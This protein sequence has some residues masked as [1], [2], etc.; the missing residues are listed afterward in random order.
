M[1][2]KERRGR[3]DR[4]VDREDGVGARGYFVHR[5]S[6][7]RPGCA[8][9]V[10]T[11]QH[12]SEDVFTKVNQFGWLDRLE[13]FHAGGAAYSKNFLSSKHEEEL[14]N[15]NRSISSSGIRSRNPTNNHYT[16]NSGTLTDSSELEELSRTIDVI[17]NHL[18]PKPTTPT[19][20]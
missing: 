11:R 19:A 12:R 15:L 1:R 2:R 4:D 6:R 7:G 3:C 16:R 9:G 13:S 17:K 18:P 20:L 14:K 10:R 5:R 8:R